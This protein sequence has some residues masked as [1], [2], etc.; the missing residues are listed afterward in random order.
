MTAEGNNETFHSY[1][2]CIMEVGDFYS[3]NSV[4]N[5]IAAYLKMMMMMSFE[6][7]YP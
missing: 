3:Q 6:K 2:D 7:Y 1:P 5:I 4:S